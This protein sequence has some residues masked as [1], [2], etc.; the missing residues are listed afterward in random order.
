MKVDNLLKI[1][2]FIGTSHNGI[3]SNCSHHVQV[4]QRSKDGHD[5]SIRQLA[6]WFI[7]SYDNL[8]FLYDGIKLLCDKY[9]ARA[10]INLNPKLDEAVMWRLMKILT[11]RLSSKNLGNPFNMMS[12]AH[13]QLPGFSSKY[14]VVDIDDPF[15]DMER[16]TN[17]IN[18][19]QSGRTGNNVIDT[20]PTKNGVHM[21]TVPFNL[22]QLTLPVG[23]DVKK[24]G[25]TLL[26]C[27]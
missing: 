11:E 20:I 5:K 15:V 26:Y 8:S 14:W 4:I 3:L 7:H 21:I 9:N 23:V 27:P 1:K 18:N 10:Y 24:D 22:S 17:D 25:L 6:E 19:C 16:L 13:D 2:P 12:S